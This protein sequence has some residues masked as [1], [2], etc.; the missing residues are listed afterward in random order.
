MFCPN[1]GTKVADGAAFCPACG[2]KLKAP[3]DRPASVSAG[4]PTAASTSYSSYGAPAAQS[5]ALAPTTAPRYAG[6]QPGGYQS[7]RQPG[8]QYGQAGAQ[9]GQASGQYGQAS[10]QHGQVGA[11]YG[12]ATGQYGQT[13]SQYA[14]PGAQYAQPGA[15]YAQYAQAGMSYQQMGMNVNV[16]DVDKNLYVWVWCFLLGGLGIDR[17]VRGQVGAGIAKILLDPLTLGI[18]WLVDWIKAMVEAYGS[19]H[20]G[21]AKQI[22]F[23]NGKYA[24]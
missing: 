11:Q 19:S 4:H 6:Q 20:F 5:R 16:K 21:G 14:Q 2:S 13:S 18:W 15:Q 23:V 10:G 3:M 24:R 12:Q 9:Y 1:C 7:H 22:R 17:F 8:A